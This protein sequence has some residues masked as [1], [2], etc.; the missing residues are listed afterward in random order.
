LDQALEKIKAMTLAEKLISGGGVLML[1][2]SFFDWWHYNAADDLGPAGELAEAFGQSLSTGSSGWG[3]P[4]SLWSVLVILICIGLAALVLAIKV[5]NVQMP[6][7]PEG[8]TWGKVFG[9]AAVAI[10][11]F[12]LLKFWRILDAP[13]GGMGIGFFI[14]LVAAVI[15]VYGCYLVYSEEKGGVIRR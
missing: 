14:G 2:A 4:G 9:G 5:G 15:V 12:M 13:V 7:L 1:I 3:A 8:V 10:V 11:L 6:A